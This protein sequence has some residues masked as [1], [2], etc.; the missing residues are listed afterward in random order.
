MCILQFILENVFYTNYYMYAIIM[1]QIHIHFDKRAF[2]LLK[3]LLS[4]E[5]N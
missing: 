3:P 4:G 5:V 1:N 2:T